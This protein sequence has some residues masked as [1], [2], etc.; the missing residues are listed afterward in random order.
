MEE[1]IKTNNPVT[2]S[3]VEALLRDA[4]IPFQ[5]LDHNMS[6]LY[7]NTLNH[8]ARRILVDGDFL[9]QARQLLRD[10]GLEKEADWS[11]EEPS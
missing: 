3:F 6:T 1:L 5:S 8:I 9:V 4:G 10:A 2:L 7:G 11:L